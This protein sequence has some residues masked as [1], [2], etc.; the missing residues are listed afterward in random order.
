MVAK[1]EVP[2]TVALP[3]EV[4]VVNVGLEVIPMVEVPVKTM[5]DPAM[6][7]ETG[8]LK[9]L[10]HCEVEAESGMS[11]PEASPGVNVWIPVDVAVTM[12]SVSPFA[13]LVARVCEDTELPLSVEILPPAP[14]ASTPQENVPLAQRSFSVEVLHDVRLAPKSDARVSPPVD[15]AL[16]NERL[17]VVASEEVI[18]PVTVADDMVVVARV[19]VPRA[20]S[21]DEKLPVVKVEAPRVATEL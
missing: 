17:V 10:D 6:R 2:E 9:K 5:L 8:V 7:Y 1:V 4:M 11:Y 14:P 12:V 16:P 18:V 13:E 19:V 20:A 15:E 3:E 21:V